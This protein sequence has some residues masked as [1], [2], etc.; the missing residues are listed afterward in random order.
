MFKKYLFMFVALIIGFSQANADVKRVLNQIESYVQLLF[1]EV[2]VSFS[3]SL[4]FQ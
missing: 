3:H 1:Q 4:H 2:Q